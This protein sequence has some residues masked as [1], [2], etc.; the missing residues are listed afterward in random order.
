MSLDQPHKAIAA[1]R[2]SHDASGPQQLSQGADLHLEVVRF[3]GQPG[4]DEV[5]EFVA[6]DGPMCVLG[7]DDQQIKCTAADTT[8]MT[9]PQQLLA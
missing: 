6:R 5:Q 7:Q 2:H 4:P 9:I 3:D 1:S 8:R